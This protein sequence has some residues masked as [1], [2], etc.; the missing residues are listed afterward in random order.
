MHGSE[1]TNPPKPHRSP[2]LENGKQKTHGSSPWPP[3]QPP[4][5]RYLASKQMPKVGRHLPWH[6]DIPIDQHSGKALRDIKTPPPYPPSTHRRVAHVGRLVFVQTQEGF[7]TASQ[8][9]PLS[10]DSHCYGATCF[11]PK[12]GGVWTGSATF[13]TPLLSLPEAPTGWPTACPSSIG[14]LGRTNLYPTGAT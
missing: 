4:P 6:F 5:P 3:Y 7:C 9:T 12:P 13:Q 1:T 2:P 14:N 11:T 8:S 10:R